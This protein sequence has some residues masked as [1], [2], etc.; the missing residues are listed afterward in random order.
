[1]CPQDTSSWLLIPSFGMYKWGGL[2]LFFGY[3]TIVLHVFV[4]YHSFFCLPNIIAFS[5]DTSASSLLALTSSV[6]STY[7]NELIWAVPIATPLFFLQ[8]SPVDEL[9]RV[10]PSRVPCSTM[11]DISTASHPYRLTTRRYTIGSWLH[12]YTSPDGVAGTPRSDRSAFSP[13]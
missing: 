5:W 4:E 13:Y 3:T 6:S 1:M 2:L 8:Y 10:G 11:S 12:L 7:T 9:H